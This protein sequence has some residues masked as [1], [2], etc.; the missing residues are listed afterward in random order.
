MAGRGEQ[1]WFV[2]VVALNCVQAGAKQSNSSERVIGVRKQSQQLRQ[3]QIS[4]SEGRNS[5][6]RWQRQAAVVR[7]QLV[8]KQ[9]L[10]ETPAVKIIM[11]KH[12][13]E[14]GK[15]EKERQLQG[16][17]RDSGPSVG[18][19]EARDFCLHV[20]LEGMASWPKLHSQWDVL[21]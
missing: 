14:R 17:Q 9:R 18:K 16:Q 8:E 2:V 3:Q 10:C 15:K 1:S 11:S 20:T 12:C 19:K 7:I 5:D 4:S 6:V 21:T 13:L